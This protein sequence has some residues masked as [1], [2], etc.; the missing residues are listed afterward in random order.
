[1]MKKILVAVDGSEKAKRA[2]RKGAELSEQLEAK[3]T[4]IHVYK[5]SAKAPVDEFN[6]MDTHL[7]DENMIDI[8][9]RHEESIVE[10]KKQ[11]LEEDAKYFTEKNIEVEK[12]FRYGDPADIVCEFAEENAFDLI[13]V[14]DKGHSK[15]GRFLLGSI[16]D[17]IVRHS[18]IS[19]LVVK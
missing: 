7:K 2:A 6:V 5:Q 10:K 11:I 9:K 19:V 14:A 4:L 13:I 15:V 8:I 17:K 1:M 18:N 12:I 3:V 16:S